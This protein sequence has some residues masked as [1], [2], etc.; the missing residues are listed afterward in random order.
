MWTRRI[1]SGTQEHPTTKDV[2]RSVLHRLIEKNVD[3]AWAHFEVV[4]ARGWFRNLLFGK[5]PWIEVALVDQRSLQLNLGFSKSRLSA[6]PSVP[7]KWRQDG[8]GLWTVPVADVE[9]LVEW[10]DMCFAGASKN[11]SYQASGWINGL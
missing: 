11:P 3:S 9:E 7:E 8:K 6:M 5:E 4:A 1:T 2:F 10:T